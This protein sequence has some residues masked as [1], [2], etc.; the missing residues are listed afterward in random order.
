MRTHS[1]TPVERD[2]VSMLSC[3]NASSAR[4]GAVV[5]RL[6]AFNPIKISQLKP[7]ELLSVFFSGV[8][9][10]CNFRIKHA[11]STWDIM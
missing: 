9:K 7:Q 8:S 2:S 10:K 6:K 1:K 5:W 4:F 3:N 11:T